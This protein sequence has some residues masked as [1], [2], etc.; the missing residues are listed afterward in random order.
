[1]SQNSSLE[2]I[3]LVTSIG[4][5]GVLLNIACN[6]EPANTFPTASPTYEAQQTIE[7]MPTTTPLL[8]HATATQVP[9]TAEP[10]T[11]EA[12]ITPIAQPTAENSD[13]CSMQLSEIRFPKPLNEE[14]A[15]LWTERYFEMYP[16]MAVFDKVVKITLPDGEAYVMNRGVLVTNRFNKSKR[17]FTAFPGDEGTSYDI[18]DSNLT[19]G[20]DAIRIRDIKK[21]RT[22]NLERKIVLFKVISQKEGS[23]S[24]DELYQKIDDYFGQ[25][26]RMIGNSSICEADA[27]PKLVE[28]WPGRNHFGFSLG[29][30]SPSLYDALI[31]ISIYAPAEH[32]RYAITTTHMAYVFM[33]KEKDGKPS[34]EIEEIRRNHDFDWVHMD[35]KDFKVKEEHKDIVHAYLK[36]M[37]IDY[38]DISGSLEKLEQ[39]YNA[40]AAFGNHWNLAAALALDPSAQLQVNAL[41]PDPNPIGKNHYDPKLSYDQRFHSRNFGGVNGRMPLKS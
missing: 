7:S 22:D 36:M 15:H 17:L 20:V 26:L 4:T 11:I 27:Q 3:V 9:P 28:I 41:V 6:S 30:Q 31:G 34:I 16:E 40:K 39:D 18:S 38:G 2:R 12:F 33:V 29:M 14:Y 21:R 23:F 24:Q 5:A 13:F 35:P 25:T 8:N 32:Q 1:M 37:S 10:Q 19:P